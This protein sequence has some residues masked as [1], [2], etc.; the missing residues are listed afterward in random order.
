M[1]KI[2]LIILLIISLISFYKINEI[3]YKKIQEI[4]FNV[5]NHPEELPTKKVALYTSFGFKNLKAD[6]YWLEAIQYIWWN[7]I[8]SEY[9]KYLYAMLDVITELNPYFEHPYIIW[10]LLLPDYNP[11]YEKLS[12]KQQKKHIN[13]AVELWL[14][15]IKNFCDAKKIENI[16]SEYNFNKLR[17]DDK[18]KNPCKSYK[19]AYNLA[20]IYFYY[21]KKP[22]LASYYFRVSYANKDSLEWSKI[23]AAI[24]KWKWWNREKAFFM[25]LDMAKDMAWKKTEQEKNC[26]NFSKFLM[27]YTSDKRFRLTWNILKK[28]E[29]TRKNI[30]PIKKDK[31]WKILD[32][33]WCEHYLNKAV[34]ELNLIYIENSNKQYFK[35]YNKNASDAEEL[36]KKWFINYLPKDP[37][38]TKDRPIYYKYNKDYWHF[39]YQ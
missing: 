9:K 6:K 27:W 33:V 19:I 12:D 15:W 29:E 30:F 24:M 39:D 13:Q 11:R 38:N 8:S 28:I 14:K 10:E 35:K 23:M 37:E 18:Y 26:S 20:Y 21:L 22:D 16:K 31:K 7:A 4:K 32:A 25:F 3:N 2:F 17:Q 36:Y 5:V 34:R 1:K